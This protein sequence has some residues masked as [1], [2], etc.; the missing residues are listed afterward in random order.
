MELLEEIISKY[1]PE[2]LNEFLYQKILNPQLIY[3]DRDKKIYRILEL[4]LNHLKV[5]ISQITPTICR[6]Y[7]FINN[8]CESSGEF[9]EHE[10]PELANYI[11]TLIDEGVNKATI[12]KF[13]RRNTSS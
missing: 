13:N 1:F 9:E 4:R 7:L 12:F 2:Y 11:N 10:D 3:I 6:F 5:S 8:I